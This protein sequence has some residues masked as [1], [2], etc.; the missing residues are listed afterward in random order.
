MGSCRAPGH[1]ASGAG[2]SLLFAG[3]AGKDFDH[4]TYQLDLTFPIRTKLLNF[5]SFLLL[6][7]FDGY[8]ESLRSYDKKSNALRLGLALLR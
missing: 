7:Y 3:W 2:P 5:E 8:G 4:F 6:Q 1:A